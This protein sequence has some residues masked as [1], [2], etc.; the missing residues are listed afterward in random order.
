MNC[1]R[2]NVALEAHQAPRVLLYGCAGCG[3][4]WLDGEASRR[5]VEAIDPNVVSAAD[6]ESRRARSLQVDV[7]KAAPCPVC[8]QPMKRMPIEQ[9]R[10]DV[11]ACEAHGVW[12]DRDE[13]QRVIRA[14][15]PP[16]ATA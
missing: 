7:A 8:T 15:A 12:F 10:V 4:L 3:G 6:D 11:D 16:A 13:L 5:V 1:P 2:C 14:V 9:A